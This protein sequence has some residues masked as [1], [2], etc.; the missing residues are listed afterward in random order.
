MKILSIQVAHAKDNRSEQITY[1]VVRQTRLILLI[2]HLIKKKCFN[3]KESGD[4][5]LKKTQKPFS[6]VAKTS[7]NSQER[8][9]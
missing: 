4:L 3:Q 7:S 9:L 8:V 2:R 1:W 5:N 6:V